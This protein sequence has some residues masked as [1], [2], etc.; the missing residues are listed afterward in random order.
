MATVSD[1]SV[2]ISIVSSGALKFSLKSH[3]GALSVETL[4][5]VESVADQNEDK[6]K[7][8]KHSILFSGQGFLPDRLFLFLYVVNIPAMPLPSSGT[9][10]PS[11]AANFSI[12]SQAVR[13]KRC[14]ASVSPGTILLFLIRMNISWIQI[15]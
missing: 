15:F 5:T 10:Y 14:S 8:F 4:Q 6:Q 1:L 11:T 7:K 2:V 9:S 12:C 3:L 13:D